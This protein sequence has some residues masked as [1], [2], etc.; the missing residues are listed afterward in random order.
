MG[1]KK[2][3]IVS[4][5]PTHPV[6]AGNCKFIFNQVELLKRMGNDV[7]F[8][9]VQEKAFRKKNRGADNTIEE[10]EK[11][12]GDHLLVFTINVINKLW[13][14]FLLKY[15]TRFNNGYMKCDDEYPWG[16]THYVSELQDKM[17]FDC[18]ITNYY[19][20]TKFFEKIHFPLTGITTHDYF[21][22]KNLLIGEKKT[23]MATTPDEEA[24]GLQRSKNIFALNSEE[25]IFFSKL[26]PK[27]KVY[28]VYSTFD[29]IETPIVG[30]HSILYLS[31]SNHFS[32]N[33]LLWFL[34]EI[35]PSIVKRFNDV[36]LLVGGSI[37]KV[38]KETTLPANVKLLGFVENP[39]DFF[40]LA[41]VSINPTYQG[42]GLKI[43]TFESVAYGKVTMTHP[44]SM[45]GIFNPNNSPVFASI[46]PKEWIKMLE[47]IWT[48]IDSVSLVKK[49][50]WNYITE[51]N[52][53]VEKQYYDF[54]AIQ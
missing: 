49:K 8:L 28:N 30:N 23:W 22:Y 44:H 7:Y 51:M 50:N 34:E 12:W 40:K 9:F 45:I 32:V 25:A 36:K 31:S 18:C 17:N 15:R 13:I 54:L 43:K 2:I 27:S 26:A 11:Y 10:M 1:G 29:N 35:F 47:H 20:M 24:K 5:C 33:G 39:S 37:C 42:T 19:N 41:D 14:N 52:S 21:S 53:Y 6:I 48:D 38:L 4:K 16:F 46:N 3:L